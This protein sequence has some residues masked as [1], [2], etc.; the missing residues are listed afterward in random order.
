MYSAHRGRD[1]RELAMSE[2][3]VE[4]CKL[5]F[6]QYVAKLHRSVSVPSRISIPVEPYEVQVTKSNLPWLIRELRR[7]YEARAAFALEAPSW[8]QPLPLGFE[9]GPLL[10]ARGAMRVLGCYAFSLELMG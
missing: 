4:R 1:Q 5:E 2:R 9:S 8:A 7:A 3:L 10:H 6:E